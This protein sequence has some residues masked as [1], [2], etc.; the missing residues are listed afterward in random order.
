MNESD[1]L[2]LKAE[3]LRAEIRY[4]TRRFILQ[5]VFALAVAFGVGIWFGRAWL[6]HP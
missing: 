4:E 3:R 6:G 1:L 5:I 2:L